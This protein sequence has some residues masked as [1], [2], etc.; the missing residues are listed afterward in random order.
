MKKTI[1]K[2][3]KKTKKTKTLVN[4]ILDK[5]GSMGGVRD[6]TIS[7]FNEYINTLKKD[8]NEYD[9]SLTLF[10]TEVLEKYVSKSLKSVDELDSKSYVPDGMT[11]LYD[12]VCRTVE[13]VKKSVSKGTKVLTV[14]MTDGCE[15]SSKEYTEK[16]MKELVKKLE[17]TKLWSF[18]YLGANQD[19][20]ANAG[21][22]GFASS[23]VSNFNSTGKGVTATF[24][25]MATNTS[26]FGGGGGGST[27]SFFSK[28]DQDKLKATK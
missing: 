21:A 28:D 17:A 9:F 2:V 3:I 20:W 26:A 1:K 19:A 7:G 18:I 12:A 8:G 14:I 24:A 10:D 5:S 27:L 22:W 23:N 16:N 4:F 13:G 6:A 25:V 11:A 15:N